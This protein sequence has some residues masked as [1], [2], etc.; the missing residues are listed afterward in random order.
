MNLNVSLT[1]QFNFNSGSL[2]YIRETL[3][4]VI[5]IVSSKKKKEKGGYIQKRRCV[6]RGYIT[7]VL[8][9]S[10]L[11]DAADRLVYW[12]PRL[13]HSIGILV[14]TFRLAQGVKKNKVVELAKVIWL[15]LFIFALCKNKK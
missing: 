12:D 11:P 8:S 13:D 4:K 7:W 1:I 5:Y 15:K 14:R 10:Q 3:Q 9:R 2:N 6:D